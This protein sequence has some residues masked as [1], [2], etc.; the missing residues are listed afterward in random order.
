MMGKVIS[1]FFSLLHWPLASAFGGGEFISSQIEEVINAEFRTYSSDDRIKLLRVDDL[2]QIDCDRDMVANHNYQLLKCDMVFKVLHTKKKTR[3]SNC[4][5][6]L[7]I[8]QILPDFLISP[9]SLES[10]KYKIRGK[11]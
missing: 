7:F 1:L 5:L 4:T 11:K 9:S 2:L 10:C 3:Y 6:D 8:N